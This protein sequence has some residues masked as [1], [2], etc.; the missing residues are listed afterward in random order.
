MATPAAVL[1]TLLLLLLF[2][3]FS[4]ALVGTLLPLLFA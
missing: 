3:C 1:G 4:R 2:V